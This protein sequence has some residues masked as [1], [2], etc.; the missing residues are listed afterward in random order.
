MSFLFRSIDE[1]RA[2]LGPILHQ[3]FPSFRT[4]GSIFSE[5]IGQ[6]LQPGKTVLDAGCGR[7]GV[8][9][10]FRDR[11]GK[12]IILDRDMAAVAA[13]PNADQRLTANLESIPLP[14][15]SVD[16]I[17]SE[18]VIEHLEQPQKVFAE[19]FRI[20]KP[21]GHV[22]VLTPN[23]HNPV[24]RLSAATPHRFHRHLRRELL[25]KTEVSFPT[26]YRANT[27]AKLRAAA[28]QANLQVEQLVLAG[29]PEYLALG[30]V[31]ATPAVLFERLLNRPSLKWMKMYIVAEL[32]RP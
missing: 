18:F 14:D 29:N 7:G 19:F 13:Y 30:P 25:H 12:L 21:G 6:A 24:I 27:P 28:G 5:W 11:I 10:S 4:G 23:T 20:L 31:F 9:T 22:I 1:Q 32:R 26:F 16:L 8:L 2:H 3:L 15:Q 17:T